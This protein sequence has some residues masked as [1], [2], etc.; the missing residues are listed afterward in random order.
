[1]GWLDRLLSGSSGYDDDVVT[2][3]DAGMEFRAGIM[4]DAQAREKRRQENADIP[5]RVNSTWLWTGDRW[6]K[7]STVW[8]SYEDLD[9]TEV[10][11]PLLD[12]L[13]EHGITPAA[14]D[15][16]RFSEGEWRAL[17]PGAPDDLPDPASQEGGSG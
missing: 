4:R 2:R 11:T 17:D 6:Q 3:P 9:Q 1:M 8:K 16:F 14:G 10:P 12:L 13:G 7:W 15:R 5:R